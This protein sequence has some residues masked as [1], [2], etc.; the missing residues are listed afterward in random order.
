MTTEKQLKK[1]LSKLQSAW[2]KATQ[3]N[4]RYQAQ[5]IEARMRIVTASLR[6]L[7]SSFVGV[8]Q[9]FVD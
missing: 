5:A 1:E 2:R 3:Q 6:N 9:Y 4:R 8:S 7:Q